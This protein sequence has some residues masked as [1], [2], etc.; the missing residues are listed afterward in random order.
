MRSGTSKLVVAILLAL[1]CF[2]VLE[3]VPTVGAQ[4]IDEIPPRLVPDTFELRSARC[5]ADPLGPENSGNIMVIGEY[6]I[7]YATE[8]LPLEAEVIS[9]VV[10]IGYQDRSQDDKIVRTTR[11][12]VNVRAG[13]GNGVYAIYLD[14]NVVLSEGIDPAVDADMVTAFLDPALYSIYV[15]ASMAVTC[16]NYQTHEA[17]QEAIAAFVRNVA[18]RLESFPEW[19][20]VSLI[21]RSSTEKFLTTEGETYFADAIPLLRFI[22]PGL[23]A[24][25]LSVPE[26][27]TRF[28]YVSEDGFLY[29]PGEV[30]QEGFT[31]QPGN[32]DRFWNM[33]GIINPG[34][35]N[36]NRLGW[37][38]VG[39]PADEG[40]EVGQVP[41]TRNP[42]W[43]P[44]KSF[45]L[46][47]VYFTL[48]LTLVAGLAMSVYAIK[49]TGSNQVLLPIM[50]VTVGS[51]GS[52]YLVPTG[53]L[54]IVS[55]ICLIVAIWILVLKRASA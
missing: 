3:L 27:R 20:Q 52:L 51:G 10:L 37:W 32:L 4:T 31:D 9:D 16:T 28:D 17:T 12:V 33:V 53:F 22:A 21:D 42:F 7:D 6:N 15:A 45:G 47:V 54:A 50:A 1:L 35:S 2:M 48:I 36:L 30:G 18:I 11:P 29:D 39:S 24:E 25:T 34:D 44:A 41:G 8:T 46:D 26:I 43:A 49:L 40:G 38:R 14:Q 13:Y 55:F 5:F 23:F 19:N